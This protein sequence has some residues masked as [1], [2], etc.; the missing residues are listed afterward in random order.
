MSSEE[1]KI[2]IDYSKT[3]QA[4]YIAHLDTIDI[5]SKALRR[6][7]LPYAVTQGCHV[8]PKISFGPPLPLGHAS[9]CEY[10]VINLLQQPDV[11]EIKTAL[12]REFPSG[13]TVKKVRYPY[14]ELRNGNFGELV[15]YRLV[16]S[17]PGTA[18]K[19]I[20]WLKSPDTVFTITHKGNEK[21]YSC[22]SALK[23]AELNHEGAQ[24]IISADF[25]QG[26]ANVPSVSKI[27][28]AL[29]SFLAEE[30]DDLKF[31]ER[32]ALIELSKTGDLLIES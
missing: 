14:K 15:S 29:A 5:I 25:Y 17:S 6:L 7:K 10:F 24:T 22:N 18:A 1:F 4:R 31:I 30:R 27:V 20:E 28:T 19:S 32:T 16:F 8:R 21:Q 3:A 2:R 23:S 11:E 13:M 26:L 9:H 12:N